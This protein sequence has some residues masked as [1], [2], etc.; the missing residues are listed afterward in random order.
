[1]NAQEPIAFRGRLSASVFPEAA[2]LNAWKEQFGRQFLNLDI[3]PL[4]A[5]LRQL[6]A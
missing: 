1:M 2:R 3:D 5:Q 4:D 6:N